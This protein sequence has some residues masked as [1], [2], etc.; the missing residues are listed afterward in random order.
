MP[1][2]KPIVRLL[3][4][5]DPHLMTSPD[6]L[7]LGVNTDASFTQV[8][9][10]ASA[11]ENVD[12]IVVTGDISGCE[13]AS[14]YQR[15]AELMQNCSIPSL[16]LGGNHDNL[17]LMQRAAAEYL[18]R[19]IEIGDW[20]I[21][22]LTSSAPNIIGGKLSASELEALDQAL[23][24]SNAAHVLLAVH[25]HLIDIGS[26]WIDPQKIANADEL[27][28]KLEQDKRVKVIIHG[29]VHQAVDVDHNGIRLLATPS[30]WAQFAP[31]TDEFTV[32]PDGQPGYRVI[33][34]HADG[35]VE[36]EV[37]RIV[38]DLGLDLSITHY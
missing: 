36:A 8:L 22:T 32:D 5:T 2:T 18:Q 35:Q 3:Q 28:E 37:K 11:E 6:H 13:S 25:H 10:A 9:A 24:D 19:S 1:A 21:V 23:A 12:L 27:F 17:A 38:V 15:M 30:T 16:W 31:R 34:L 20:L 29:H 33:D 7:M 26:A 4:L 14:S